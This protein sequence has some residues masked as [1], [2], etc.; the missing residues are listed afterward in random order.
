MTTSPDP[1]MIDTNVLVHAGNPDSPWHAAAL[2]ALEQLDAD[3]TEVWISTQIVREFLV[4]MTRP[5][6]RGERPI[7]AVLDQAE[8]L[9]R[10]YRVAG[11]S[12]KTR[13]IL[14]DLVERHG[15]QGKQ[16]HDANIAATCVAYGV[17]RLLTHNGGDFARYAPAIVV[18]PL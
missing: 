16:V 12:E 10:H 17:P 18:V 8:E 5:D 11:E 4:Q 14:F 3:Q 13:M 6:M 7:T 9:C 15:V 2:E 1:L